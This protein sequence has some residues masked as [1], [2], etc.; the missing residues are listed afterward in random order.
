MHFIILHHLS[1][2]VL[3]HPEF[4]TSHYIHIQNPANSDNSDFFDEDS[5]NSDF[6]DN[7]NFSDEISDNSNDLSD[8]SNNSDFSDQI[9]DV[10][11]SFF[12]IGFIKKNSELL[13]I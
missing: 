4:L 1:N 11:Q 9:S 12:F 7:S 10:P 2:F 8:F 5:D 13:E 6:S 3:V